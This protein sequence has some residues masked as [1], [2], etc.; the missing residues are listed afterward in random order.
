MARSSLDVLMIEELTADV[1]SPNS[2]KQVIDSGVQEALVTFN[3][4]SEEAEAETPQ[5][6]GIETSTTTAVR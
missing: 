1:T 4:A 5:I 3:E 2:I 6:L